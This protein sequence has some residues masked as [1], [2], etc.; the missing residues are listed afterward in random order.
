LAALA[1]DGQDARQCKELSP[2]INPLRRVFIACDSKMKMSLVGTQRPFIELKSAG[3][4]RQLCG[5]SG[6]LQ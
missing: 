4:E 6:H 2:V 3:C 5:E 1:F